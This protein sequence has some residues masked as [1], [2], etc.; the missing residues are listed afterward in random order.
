MKRFITLH[1][2]KLRIVEKWHLFDTTSM[3]KVSM[4]AERDKFV[5]R[6]LVFTNCSF[7]NFLASSAWDGKRRPMATTWSLRALSCWGFLA[8]HFEAL[9]TL[10]TTFILCQ[11]STKGVIIEPR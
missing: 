4:Q 6:L 1:T 9:N 8:R 2:K 3:Q 11:K 10:L 5:N 7:Y